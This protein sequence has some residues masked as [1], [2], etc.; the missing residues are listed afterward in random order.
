MMSGE[1]RGA[2]QAA[3]AAEWETER[4]AIALRRWCE[5]IPAK[6][7]A[8]YPLNPAVAEWVSKLVAGDTGN[9]VMLGGTGTTKTWNAWHAVRHALQAGWFGTARFFSAYAWKR[10][11]G[12]PL[13]TEEITAAA[14]VDL[15]VLDDPGA[16]R[17]GE[18]DLENL[19]GVIDE[20]WNNERPTIFTSNAF[21]L[22]ELFGPRITSRIGDGATIV[23]FE[24][25]DLRRA[26]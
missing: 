10:V 17:L 12:P 11:I 3:A 7:R 13:D 2:Q 4:Q 14:T 8:E 23:T 22:H 20:R 19:L 26:R 9:L 5:Q 16:H 6:Q 24:G 15:L 25:D 21:K 18:W 1:D